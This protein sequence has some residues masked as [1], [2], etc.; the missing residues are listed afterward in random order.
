MPYD[1]HP[2]LDSHQHRLANAVPLSTLVASCRRVD[3]INNTHSDHYDDDDVATQHDAPQ[4]PAH[5]VNNQHDRIHDTYDTWYYN[6]DTRRI[7]QPTREEVVGQLVSRFGPVVQRASSMAFGTDDTTRITPDTDVAVDSNLWMACGSQGVRVQTHYDTVENVLVQL[8]GEKIVT[9]AP[10]GTNHVIPMPFLS[11]HSRHAEPHPWVHGMFDTNTDAGEEETKQ[12]TPET[13]TDTFTHTSSQQPSAQTTRTTTATMPSPGTPTTT[14]TSTTD[15]KASPSNA[16]TQATLTAG[17]ALYIPPGYWHNI[18]IPSHVLSVSVSVFTDS[19]LDT[20][21]DAVSRL[22][23]DPPTVWDTTHGL[24]LYVE[25]LTL[26]VMGQDNG[27]TI[28]AD[29]VHNVSDS[30]SKSRPQSRSRHRHATASST[31]TSTENR[32][33]VDGDNVW[34]QSSTMQSQETYRK[35]K[36]RSDHDEH[37]SSSLCGPIWRKSTVCERQRM[38][39]TDLIAQIESFVSQTVAQHWRPLQQR[40]DPMADVLPTQLCAHVETVALAGAVGDVDRVSHFLLQCV[41]HD[42]G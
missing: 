3:A 40:H 5:G 36:D 1:P 34:E 42:G 12:A 41:L 20:L 39:P 29:V 17:D 23:F 11:V 9:L 33:D 26:A 13:A 19:V 37:T 4:R 32:G 30:L 35:D 21:A 28:V 22:P 25:L 31:T 6:G 27:P 16:W 7:P 2:P 8:E 10:P 14:S 18:A 24:A 15:T 38:L